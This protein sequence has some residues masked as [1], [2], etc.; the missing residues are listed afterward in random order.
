[1][2]KLL[3]LLLVLAGPAH[4][5]APAI[6]PF[7]P[8]AFIGSPVIGTCTSGYFLYDNGG[9]IG[10]TASSATIGFPQAV[11]GGVSGGIPYFS[12]TTTMSASLLLA[13]NAIMIGG[14]SG[15]APATTTTGTGVLTAV[16]NAVNTNG[17]LVTAST[18]SIASGALLTGGGSATA[19]SAI[20]PGTGVA[21]ALAANANNNTSG[22]MTGTG[23][24]T[25]PAIGGTT[26]AA[27]S[28]T[29]LT[30]SGTTTVKVRSLG[31]S[32]VTVSATTDYFLCLDP[33]S[34]VITVNLPASPATGLTYLIKDCTGQAATHN[35]TVTPNAGNVDG[36]GTFVMSTAYQSIAVTYTGSQW[37]IN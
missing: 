31:T 3:A 12:N 26:P 8:G 23:L 22:F 17:G 11:T 18:A 10:C 29:T 19:I 21:T 25:P 34:N 35:I 5:A 27:G 30:L 32:P 36:A 7:P 20:T 33:T 2:K 4:A 13:A 16:G 15:T 28:F 14:G 6:P 9:V 24:A 1:V 37:S